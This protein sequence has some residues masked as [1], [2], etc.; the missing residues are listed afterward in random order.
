MAMIFIFG[1]RR[2]QYFRV[3]LHGV[4]GRPTDRPSEQQAEGEIRLRRLPGT[5]PRVLDV[6]TDTTV[7]WRTSDF[8][9]GKRALAG[10]SSDAS[11]SWY[12]VMPLSANKVTTTTDELGNE[13][14]G[15]PATPRSPNPPSSSNVFQRFW[16]FGRATD[17]NSKQPMTTTSV[18]ELRL[19]F[20]VAMPSE[21]YPVYDRKLREDRFRHEGGTLVYELGVHE[22]PWDEDGS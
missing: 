9:P 12:N 18:T 10:D 17:K 8:L 5:K 1:F 14:V 19:A 3:R 15:R 13:P 2:Y 22:L 11:W 4:F 21:R 6:C 7:R 20:L 16:R